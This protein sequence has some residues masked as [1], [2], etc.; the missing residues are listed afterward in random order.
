MIFLRLMET[1]FHHLST[2]EKVGWWGN[3]QEFFGTPVLLQTSV[4][5][6]CRDSGQSLPKWSSWA[7]YN[8]VG[9]ASLEGWSKSILLKYSSPCFTFSKKGCLPLHCQKI[10]SFSICVRHPKKC[11]RNS[12]SF[13][14]WL[15]WDRGKWVEIKR[16][17]HWKKHLLNPLMV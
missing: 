5:S 6:E 9:V 8:L 14:C 10:S 7:A 17:L 1:L 13:Y 11:K 2:T 16:W 15:R 12:H 3:N 4:S